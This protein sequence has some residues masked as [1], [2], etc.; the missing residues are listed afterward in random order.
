MPIVEQYEWADF[1]WDNADRDGARVL[2]I[3]DSI[4]RG[5]WPAVSAALRGV[6]FVDRL[7]TSK[8]PDHPAYRY[9]LDYFLQQTGLAYAAIH[10]NNGLHAAH[11]SAADYGRCLESILVHLLEAAGNAKVMLATSTPVTVPSRATQYAAFNEQVKQRNAE[12]LR[13]AQRYGL[14]VDDLYAAAENRPELRLA[15][16]C[17]YTEDGYRLLGG[18]VAEK[19]HRLL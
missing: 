17:H 15:D 3:G 12:V 10:F 4:A 18:V 7:A 8:G 5:Y 1:W 13:L 16:G 2:L 6:C 11:L 19:L 14:P 9:E